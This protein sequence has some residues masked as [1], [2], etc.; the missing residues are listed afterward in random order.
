MLSRSSS[1]S[2]E[3]TTR[4]GA[5]QGTRGCSRKGAD[6]PHLHAAHRRR[7]NLRG[8][9]DGLVEV[10]RLD[11]LEPGELLLGLG[12]GTVGHRHPSVAH[13]HR[14]GGGDRL[15]G[16]RGD[17]LA[18]RAICSVVRPQTSRSV[19]AT[20]AS[21]AS[22][23]WQQVKISRRRSS[24]TGSSS[25]RL[26]SAGASCVSGSKVSNRLRRRSWS[27]L[28]NRPAETSQACGLSGTPCAV[29]YWTLPCVT[30]AMP[31]LP[32]CST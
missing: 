10:A 20:C 32:C 13:A 17:A 27:M 9:L 24:R 2:A 22:A 4:S 7:R 21:G 26:C 25:K 14:G 31:T 8:D 6:G 28:R 15:Q 1:S 3:R 11:E 19:S 18:A 30:N 5:G 23:G 12:K 29:R 16:L